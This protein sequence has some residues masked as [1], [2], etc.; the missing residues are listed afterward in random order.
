[1]GVAVSIMATPDCL[2][3]GPEMCDQCLANLQ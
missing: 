1:M 2:T 3:D